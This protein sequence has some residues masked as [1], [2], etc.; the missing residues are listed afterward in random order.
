MKDH[1]LHFSETEPEVE[2]GHVT[3]PRPQ[4]QS[5]ANPSL[6]TGLCFP[7]PRLLHTP[8][9]GP[10]RLS[11]TRL[12]AAQSYTLHFQ[13]CVSVP[14]SCFKF[15]VS[16]SPTPCPWASVISIGCH[17]SPFLPS[18]GVS[19]ASMG[20]RLCVLFFPSISFPASP[21]PSVFVP[22]PPW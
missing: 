15:P 8:I 22:E 16:A 17:L 2:R 21:S 11:E 7:R 18:Q 10:L 1:S 9:S 19:S 14:A 5:V 3:Q 13:A 6:E 20:E 12:L 4:S